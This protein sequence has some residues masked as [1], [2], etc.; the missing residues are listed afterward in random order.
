MTSKMLEWEEEAKDG[1]LDLDTS[2]GLEGSAYQG[3]ASF[4]KLDYHQR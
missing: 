4:G 1:K 3:L 2:F